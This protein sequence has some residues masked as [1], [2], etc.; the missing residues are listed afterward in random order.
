MPPIHYLLASR[1]TDP[2]GKDG[3]CCL[4]IT[5]DKL[6]RTDA[7]YAGVNPSYILTGGN[8]LLYAANEVNTECRISI[9]TVSGEGIKPQNLKSDTGSYMLGP[10]QGAC[11][12]S[13][14]KTAD[15]LFASCYGSGHINCFDT[16]TRALKCSF[17][18]KDT[19]NSHAHNTVISNDGKWL[20]AADLGEDKVYTFHME[21]ILKGKMEPVDFYRFS[22]GTGPRQILAGN[23]S[24]QILCVNELDSSIVLFRS[25]DSTGKLYPVHMEASTRKRLPGVNNYPGTAVFSKSGRY[26]IVPNR[27]ANTLALFEVGKNELKWKYEC[28][29]YGNWPRY[30]TFTEDGNYLLV[31]NQKSGTVALFAYCEEADNPFCFLDSIAVQEVSC[32]IAL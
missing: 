11:Y 2:A 8:G 28:D 25:D 27:G 10:G 12:L 3:I 26:L 24:N 1:Y 21:E 13:L 20:Y 7:S 9:C 16:R 5:G 15:L 14:A 18:P 4:K 6:V 30:T 22:S 31:A 32:V 29:C 19:H 23:Y 17:L